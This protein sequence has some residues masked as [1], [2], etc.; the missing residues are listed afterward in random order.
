MRTV[1]LVPYRS[2][3][4]R[5]DVLWKFTA[6]W[7]AR[8]HPEYPIYVGES[9]TGL[10]NRSAA[11]NH[12]AELAGDWDVAV[13]CDSDTLV[14]PSQFEDAVAQAHSTGRLTSALTQV[15]E[16]SEKSTDKFLADPNIDPSTLPSARTRKSEILT[17]SSV[18]AV[19]RPLWDAIGGFDDKFTGWGCEDNAFWLAAS[20]VAADGKTN[21]KP[22]RI[23]G[24]AFHLWHLPVKKI[25]I[26][27]PAFRINQKRLRLYKK[28]RTPEQLAG[29]RG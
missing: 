8:H 24:P 23:K 5:R 13:V 10:F 22:L 28:S 2:D 21:G 27:D 11:I 3:G 9:P 4:G 6:E 19:P 17:Q 7:L 25:K 15:I 18:I 14:S 12:A 29:L 20:I 1:I 16:L 26:L